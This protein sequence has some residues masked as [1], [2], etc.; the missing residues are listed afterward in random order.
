MPV[1]WRP[2]LP[3]GVRYNH[4]YYDSL[5]L[6]PFRD[7]PSNDARHENKCAVRRKSLWPLIW[8]RH[9]EGHVHNAE[10]EGKAD[11]EFQR[12]IAIGTS[13]TECPCVSTAIARTIR[14]RGSS[15]AITNDVA[16]PDSL[17][18]PEIFLR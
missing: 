7:Q 17:G 10:I 8:V 9:P 12:V 4:R 2:L 5:E 14:M 3:A 16:A 13:R 6:L 11:D 15:S 18:H 1:E